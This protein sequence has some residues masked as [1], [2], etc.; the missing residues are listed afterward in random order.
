MKRRQLLPSQLAALTA[1]GSREICGT[2]IVISRPGI[3]GVDLGVAS[4]L[5]EIGIALLG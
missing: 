4:E 3:A 2:E 5:K 1:C